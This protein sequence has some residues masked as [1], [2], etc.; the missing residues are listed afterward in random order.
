M[1]AGNRSETGGVPAD[2]LLRAM[3]EPVAVFASCGSLLMA[4]PAM[5]RWLEAVGMTSYPTDG[6]RGELFSRLLRLPPE[7]P[8]WAALLPCVGGAALWQSTTLPR[9]WYLVWES[10][11]PTC[12][13]GE[14]PA[15][16]L[17]RLLD[18]SSLAHFEIERGHDAVR[19]EREIASLRTQLDQAERFKLELTANVTHDLRTPL[20]SIKASVS[21]LLAG[22][23]AYDRTALR[24]TLLVVEEETDRLQRRVQNLLSL[25]R[26]E[27][28]NA[29]LNQDWVDLA[30]V[31]ATAAESLRSIGAGREVVLDF[32]DDLPLV[33]GDYDQI[34][35]A[36]R[37]LLENALLYSPRDLAVEVTGR[38]G[39][40]LVRVRVR[41]YGPGLMPD[42]TE[43]VFDKFY[44]GRANRHIPGTG[45]GLPICRGIAEAHGGRLWAEHVPGGGVQFV[46]SLPT[47]DASEALDLEG[48]R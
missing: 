9:R 11:I 46:L 28:G 5:D 45:L 20:A 43:R 40:G 33:R 39:L 27:S 6:L 15:P 21:G 32:P 16:G 4:N 34:L 36:V 35:I 31:A 41:D 13:S 42:E 19:R 48:N 12:T 22:D 2:D 3:P 37:N 14:D 7:R 47:A 10:P 18:V 29:D 24:E 23:V 25:A 44:R 17:V 38:A 30:D 1:R 8:S 26:M